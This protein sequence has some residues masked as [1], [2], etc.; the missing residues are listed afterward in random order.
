MDKSVEEMIVNEIKMIGQ[1]Q[2]KLHDKVNVLKNGQVRIDEN[3]KEHMRRTE[4]AEK[5]I[6]TLKKAL[7]PIAIHVNHMEGAL[8]FIGLLSVVSTVALAIWQ[9]FFTA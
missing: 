3:L 5:A 2:E 9:I 6:D 8:K 4:M 7:G 1:R